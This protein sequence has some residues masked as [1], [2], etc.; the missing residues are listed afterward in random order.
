LYKHNNLNFTD[1]H[2]LHKYGVLSCGAERL[3]RVAGR[4][5]RVPAYVTAWYVLVRYQC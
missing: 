1:S 2:D 5:C 3:R 4:L